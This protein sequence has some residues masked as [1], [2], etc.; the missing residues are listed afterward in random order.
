MKRNSHL[1]PYCFSLLAAAAMILGSPA[2]VSSQTAP[3]QTMAPQTVA[4]QHPVA[5]G[6]RDDDLTRRQLAEFDQFLD[7]HPEIAE[8]LRKDPSLVDNRRFVDDHASLHEFLAGH[9]HV[10]EEYKEHPNAFMRDEERFDHHQ[11]GN[12]DITR[13]EL[14]DMDQFLDRHPEIAEQLRKDPSLVDNKRF[15]GDHPALQEFLAG[16]PNTSE[17]FKENPN[18]FM[19]DED[20]FDHRE[21]AFR[22]DRGGEMN[23]FHDFLASH[24]SIASELSKDPSLANNHEY[25]ETHPELQAYLKANPSVHQQLASNPQTALQLAQP[26]A[27]TTTTATPKV[28]GESKPK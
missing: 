24:N 21:D 5:P 28:S 22:H 3:S 10:S 11:D 26:P 13:R 6:L 15:V 19:R 4:P 1:I 20:R 9:P 2:K 12:H 17:E 23:G 16:H 8:Q 18:A 7:S 25:L 27:T 14:A